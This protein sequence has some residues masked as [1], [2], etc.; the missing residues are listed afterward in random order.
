[1]PAVLPDIHALVV[2][3]Q[4]LLKRWQ[5]GGAD[6]SAFALPAIQ[7]LIDWKWTRFCK[8]L[9]LSELAFFLVWLFSFF[10]FC[11]LFQVKGMLWRPCCSH[12]AQLL[13]FVCASAG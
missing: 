3:S 11:I 8:R 12:S 9:L 5:A 2:P 1:M 6:F 7:A 13:S 4:P 10:S